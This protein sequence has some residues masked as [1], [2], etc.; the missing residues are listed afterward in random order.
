MGTLVETF[1]FLLWVVRPPLGA[2]MYSAT[3]R[4]L[5]QSTPG[6]DLLQQRDGVSIRGHP[7]SQSVLWRCPC[8]SISPVGRLHVLTKPLI[9]SSY[10]RGHGVLQIPVPDVC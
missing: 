2:A 3:V 4:A 10:R 6:L 8:P 1:P 5:H 9:C 7:Q